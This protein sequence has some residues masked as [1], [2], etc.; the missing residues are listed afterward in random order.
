M[1][2]DRRGRRR[3][4]ARHHRTGRRS[5]GIRGQTEHRDEGHRKLDPRPRR[6]A[7]PSRQPAVQRPGAILLLVVRLVPRMKRITLLGA[8]GSIGRRTLELVSSFPEE[9]SVVGLAAL[10]T[11][12]HLDAEL[13]RTYSPRGG[14]TLDTKARCTLGPL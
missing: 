6:D 10:G 8:T 3:R 5:R 12:V 11:D 9:F 2:R 13:C 1:Q 7:G 4:G 14:T